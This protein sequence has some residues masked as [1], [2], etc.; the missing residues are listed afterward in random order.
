VPTPTVVAQPAASV[1]TAEVKAVEPPQPTVAS[2]VAVQAI[3]VKPTIGVV[4][5]DCY[6]YEC[7]VTIC[8]NDY[9]QEIFC[10][11]D[12]D[13]C[14]KAYNGRCRSIGCEPYILQQTCTCPACPVCGQPS[15][16]TEKV[17]LCYYTYTDNTGEKAKKEV[18]CEGDYK[19]CMEKYG[20]CNCGL[21]TEAI[22]PTATRVTTAVPVTTEES[23]CCKVAVT[24]NQVV[25]KKYPKSQ[26]A[27]CV[28]DSLCA[29]TSSSSTST[30][31][32]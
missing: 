29:Q 1:E 7:K 22:L 32:T 6:A 17:H 27:S 18:R 19:S 2:P 11:K 30:Q 8:V 23:C 5:A 13:S 14:S 15:E 20:W 31:Q 16:C 24:G 12:Y 21:Q 9:Q 28:E 4:R 26:C 3:A 25:Y 10:P